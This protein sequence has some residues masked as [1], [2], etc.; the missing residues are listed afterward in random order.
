MKRTPTWGLGSLERLV[1]QRR[2]S[3]SVGS[4]GMVLVAFGWVAGSLSW[5]GTPS[6][7]CLKYKIVLVE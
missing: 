4:R 3:K 1:Q 7:R 5:I 2:R 6:V